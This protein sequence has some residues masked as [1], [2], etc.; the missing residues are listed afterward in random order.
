MTLKAFFDMLTALFTLLATTEGQLQ[1]AEWRA[2]RVKLKADVSDAIAWFKSFGIFKF[3]VF[4][5]H[6]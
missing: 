3:K 4:N 6:D 5:L 2:D 1:M